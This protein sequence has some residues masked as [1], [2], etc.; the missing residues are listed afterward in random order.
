MERDRGIPTWRGDRC[1]RVA[2]K[3]PEAGAGWPVAGSDGR[4]RMRNRIRMPVPA[5]ERGCNR[6]RT[7]ESQY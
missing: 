3:E 5:P 6:L 7:S 2:W 1:C 4:N